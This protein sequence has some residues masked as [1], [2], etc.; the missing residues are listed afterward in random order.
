MTVPFRRIRTGD[1]YIDAVQDNVNEALRPVIENP[2]MRGGL[3]EFQL[4]S[5]VDTKVPHRLGTVPQGFFVISPD[6]AARV[7]QVDPPTK[8]FLILRSDAQVSGSLYVF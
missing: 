4:A 6:S 1:K 5:G 2:L 3:V 8:L 7:W